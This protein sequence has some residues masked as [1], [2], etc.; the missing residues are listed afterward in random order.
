[1]Q[2]Y[3]IGDEG[4]L[5]TELSKGPSSVLMLLKIAAL[6]GCQKVTCCSCSS[7][8]ALPYLSAME[9][10]ETRILKCQNKKTFLVKNN[11]TPTLGEEQERITHE[12]GNDNA[13]ND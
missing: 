7:A 1:M 6:V 8:V 11:T 9:N 3:G 4:E 12:S 13:T 2:H 5:G 10:N